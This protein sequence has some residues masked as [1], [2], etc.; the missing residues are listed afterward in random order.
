M[1]VCMCVCVA[2][3]FQ[4]VI[5]ISIDFH[6]NKQ[7]FKYASKCLS[8]TRVTFLSPRKACHFPWTRSRQD[9]DSRVFGAARGGNHE[10][11]YSAG[12]PGMQPAG[13]TSLRYNKSTNQ[14]LPTQRL[15][16]CIKVGHAAELYPMFT[17]W[18]ISSGLGVFYC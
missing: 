9:R 2:D 18:M 6:I 7:I 16:L 5:V 8:S 1:R 3:Q 17:F 14:R 13:C 4:V 12:L 10:L 15:R 11:E